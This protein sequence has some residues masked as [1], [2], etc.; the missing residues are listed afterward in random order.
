[1]MI[2]FGYPDYGGMYGIQL[3]FLCTWLYMVSLLRFAVNNLCRR[4]YSAIAYVNMAEA[5]SAKR[6]KTENDS[7]TE[8]GADTVIGSNSDEDIKVSRRKT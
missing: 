4:S 3:G 2:V 8:D 5:P 1:M 6:S 7:E